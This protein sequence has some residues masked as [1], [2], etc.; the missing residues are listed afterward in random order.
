MTV[1]PGLFTELYFRII[2]YMS[3]LEPKMAAPGASYVTS[4]NNNRLEQV[5]IQYITLLHTIVK[6]QQE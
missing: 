1:E 5:L 4:L 6:H 3:I 2:Y